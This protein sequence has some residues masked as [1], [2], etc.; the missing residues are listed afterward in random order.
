MTLN[1]QFSFA[2]QWHLSLIGIAVLIRVSLCSLLVHCL[3][4]AYCTAKELD[5]SYYLSFDGRFAHCNESHPPTVWQLV[6]AANAISLSPYKYGGGHG[7]HYQGGFDCSG[8]LS[9]VLMRG[10]LLKAPQTST[11]FLSY[12]VPGPGR[13]V[14]IF[15]KPGHHVFMSICGLRFDTSGGSANQGP[16]WRPTPCDWEGFTIRHPLGL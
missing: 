13:Y 16:R 8:A 15:V 14:T 7:E 10:R 5:D 9:H 6:A 2:H 3:S 4:A 1:H 12:G 11:Q